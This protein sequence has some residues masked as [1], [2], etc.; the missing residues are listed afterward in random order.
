MYLK[1]SFVLENSSFKFESDIDWVLKTVFK[2][3]IVVYLND[4]LIFLCYLFQH[5]KQIQKLFKPCLKT[6]L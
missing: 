4:G 6:A 2:V 1:M 3:T 5:G